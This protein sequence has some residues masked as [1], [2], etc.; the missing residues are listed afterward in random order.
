MW[1][2]D[3]QKEQKGLYSLTSLARYESTKPLLGCEELTTSLSI[4]TH[5]K[6]HRLPEHYRRRS[7][8][9]F[10]RSSNSPTLS[11]KKISEVAYQSVTPYFPDSNM[12][13]HGNSKHMVPSESKLFPFIIFRSVTINA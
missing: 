13:E 11:I 4:N 7:R 2:A 10:L 8:I 3:A 9:L 12:A 6:A 5:S 1:D